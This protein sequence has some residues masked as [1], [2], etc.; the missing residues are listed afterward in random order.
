MTSLPKGFAIGASSKNNPRIKQKANRKESN[1]GDLPAPSELLPP[2]LTNT[3]TVNTDDPQGTPPKRQKFIPPENSM[4]HAFLGAASVPHFSE[5]EIK[6][7]S[8]RTEE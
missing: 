1:S 8:F 2:K 3:E 6:K 5:D 7:W 4:V